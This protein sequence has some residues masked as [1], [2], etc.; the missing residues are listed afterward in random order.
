MICKL[1]EFQLASFIVAHALL[2][3]A[4][5]VKICLKFIPILCFLHVRIDSFPAFSIY[6]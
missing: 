1:N 4:S 3:L 5:Y 2:V 6:A